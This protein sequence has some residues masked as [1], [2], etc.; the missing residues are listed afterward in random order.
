[1][2][3]SMRDKSTVMQVRCR[4][5]GFH[6]KKAKVAFTSNQWKLMRDILIRN[7]VANTFSK[8]INN[9]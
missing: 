5:A 8:E 6:H 2:I 4:D 3:V 9:Y 7:M 1:M